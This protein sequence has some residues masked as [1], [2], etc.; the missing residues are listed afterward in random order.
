MNECPFRIRTQAYLDGDLPAAEVR[1][2]Q[3]HLAGCAVCG[4]ELASY[5]RVFALLE[6][7]PLDEPRAELTER[8]LAQVLPSRIR[9]RREQRLRAFGWG[10]AGAL[11]ASLAAL[12]TWIAHPAGQAVL[13]GLSAVASRRLL[14]STKFVV[15]A[16]SYAFVHLATG[17]HV[18]G[19]ALERFAPLGRAL[20]AVISE[21]SIVGTLAAA[22]VVCVTMLWWL[23]PRDARSGRGIR[24]VGVLG[25]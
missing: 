1:A 19:L 21:T 13:S 2:Y 7:V 16:A 6:A 23:R 15:Q 10:Y 18:L 4:A 12:S 24:H 14:E 9:Q 8:V 22:L 11:A 5:R 3:A 17:W 25:F 20:G